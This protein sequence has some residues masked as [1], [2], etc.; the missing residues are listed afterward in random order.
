MPGPST[1]SESGFAMPQATLESCLFLGAQGTGFFQRSM[2]VRV[3]LDHGLWIKTLDLSVGWLF[4]DLFCGLNHWGGCR[5]GCGQLSALRSC[6]SYPGQKVFARRLG[7]SACHPKF[8]SERNRSRVQVKVEKKG[9][10]F[11]KHTSDSIITSN[12]SNSSN[13]NSSNSSKTLR[14]S[15]WVW[16]VQL[17]SSNGSL[18]W[19]LALQKKLRRFPRKYAMMISKDISEICL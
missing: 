2:G 1:S 10:T 12:S 7:Q 16:K 5:R 6:T 17:A 14:P 15:T 8:N 13:S 3:R 18:V 4:G 11:V 9:E 19:H